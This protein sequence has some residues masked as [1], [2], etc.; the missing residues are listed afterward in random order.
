M[1]GLEGIGKFS[2]FSTTWRLIIQSSHPTHCTNEIALSA[3]IG[4]NVWKMNPFA[5]GWKI[6]GAIGRSPG[7]VSNFPTID[8]FENGVA[9]SIK[10]IDLGAKSYQNLQTLNN[11]LQGYV[12]KVANFNGATYGGTTIEA[13]DITGRQL[14]LAIPPN[15]TEEQLNVIKQVTTWA[16]EQGVNVV[17]QVVR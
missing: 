2:G 14:L 10:S 8:R 4:Q 17:T 16:A 9:T 1:G 15:A 13:S 5:R 11:T 7:L 6:E 3:K 12:T